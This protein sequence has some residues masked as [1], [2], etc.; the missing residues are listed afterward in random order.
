MGFVYPS[1]KIMMEA[2]IRRVTVTVRW[3]DGATAREFVL[4]QYVTNPQRGGFAG[5]LPEGGV[6]AGLPTGGTGGTSGVPGASGLA[7]RRGWIAT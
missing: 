5:G 4:V 7:P 3:K 6:G 1:L 2:S